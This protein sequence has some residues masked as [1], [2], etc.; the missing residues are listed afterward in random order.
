[1]IYAGL[2]ITRPDGPARGL[3]KLSQAAYA[4]RQQ[5]ARKE[6]NDYS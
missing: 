6:N 2:P 3:I 1:M 4:F 5:E